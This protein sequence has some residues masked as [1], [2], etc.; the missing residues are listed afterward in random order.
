MIQ[1]QDVV[2]LIRTQVLSTPKEVGPETK[3]FSTGLLDSLQLTTL[4][5]TLEKEFRVTVGPFDVSQ[6]NFDTPELIA[7]WLNQAKND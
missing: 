1:A 7:Q 5:L 2:I 4:F 3:L 6:E